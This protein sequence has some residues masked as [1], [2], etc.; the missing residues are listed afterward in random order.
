MKHHFNWLLISI[1]FFSSITFAIDTTSNTKS[2][3]ITKRIQITWGIQTNTKQIWDGHAEID[4]GDILKVV[5]FIRHGM[6]DESKLVTRLSW[7]S[8]SYNDVEG[9]FLFVQ[10]PI[11]ARVKI[12]TESHTFSFVLDDLI[13]QKMQIRMDGDI[14]VQ[15]ITDQV[16]YQIKG[17]EYGEYGRGSASISPQVAYVDSFG[18][19]TITYTAD[20]NIPVGG[21]IRISNHF[22]RTLPT[23]QFNYQ[24]APNYVSV[25]TT[26]KSRLDYQSEHRG[27]FEY[28]FT[29]LRMLIRILDK[30]LLAGEQIIIILGDKS[31]GSPGFKAPYVSENSFEFRIES[32]TEVPETGF[33]IYR[34]IKDFPSLN[35]KTTLSP[36]RIFAVAPSIAHPK[37]PFS[38]KLVVEDK[39][40]NTIEDFSGS[41]KLFKK[42]STKKELIESYI[43]TKAN[44]G[45]M[46][47][48][49]LKVESTGIYRF[50]IETD[51]G[52]VSESNTMLYQE[53]TTTYKIF[54]GELHGHTKYSDGYESA[55][56]YYTF[57]KEKALLD[58][59]AITDHDVELD[60]PDYTVKE[61]WQKNQSANS[62]LNKPSNFITILG[63]EWSPNRITQTTEYPYGD[64]NIYYFNKIGL[65]FPTGDD[66]Y[67]T[68][69]ELYQNLRLANSKTN[70]VFTIPHVG[71]AVANLEFHDLDVEPLVEIYSV[72]GSFESFGQIALDKG[73]R[74]G[75]VG[76]SDSHNGQVGGFPPGGGA[77]HF[78]HGGLTAIYAKD[79]SR[80][81]LYEAFINHRCYATT[82]KRILINFKINDCFMGE[83]I[84]VTEP[85][86]IKVDVI[87]ENPVWKV[88]LIKNGKIIHSYFNPFI[89]DNKIT[90]LWQNRIEKNDL[91]NF[92]SGFWGRR[93]RTVHWKGKVV[94]LNKELK[95]LH[96]NSFDFPK[97]KIYTSTSDSIVW[98]SDTRGDYDGISFNVKNSNSEFQLT[99]NTQT[100]GTSAISKGFIQSLADKEQLYSYSIKSKEIDSKGLVYQINP[101][102]EI[103]IL[104]GEPQNYQS[105][106]EFIDKSLLYRDNYYYI[107]VTQIDGEIAWSSP[108]WVRYILS[109]VE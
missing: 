78:S 97:D 82:G 73:Y 62:K 49:N 69:S 67:N 50:I 77:N 27:L 34:R 28:P 90:I 23:P 76:G 64:H 15:D 14:E 44:K 37:E 13:K 26:G 36:H 108:I 85:P 101:L 21:G 42:S 12:V 46:N 35:I 51:A 43:F 87:G 98:E 63:W 38:L 11:D 58:F 61:M 72:H 30:P 99:F 31:S 48:N 8:M 33:P 95:F 20:K 70:K 80:E 2:T 54:W 22:T 86:K 102:D 68:I 79:L 83:E 74:M 94:S 25:S 60:A 109:E 18:T 40:R 39:Y 92:E 100:F 105:E 41:I 6:I 84:F 65:M 107:R 57:A 56:D 3:T 17:L 1:L 45:K 88:D 4:T 71:G 75:F 91:L 81:S 59:A 24:K 32:C 16:I 103:I 29:K 93:L 9:V 89:S 96:S 19:W 55:N 10:A 53:D 52:L 47:I 104:K 7:K 106:F 66:R 5:P